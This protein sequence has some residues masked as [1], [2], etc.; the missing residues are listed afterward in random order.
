[1]A[2]SMKMTVLWD[3]A[4]CS[5]VEIDISDVS[6]GLHDATSQKTVSFSP[7]MCLFAVNIYISPLLR[8]VGCP[9]LSLLRLLLHC[10]IQ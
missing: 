6:T 5:L 1:M 9:S 4:P 10:V 8:S 3:V 7:V 2:A